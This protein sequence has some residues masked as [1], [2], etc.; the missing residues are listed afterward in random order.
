MTLFKDSLSP[1]YSIDIP[2]RYKLLIIEPIVPKY[3]NEKVKKLM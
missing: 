3:K 1:E 2:S